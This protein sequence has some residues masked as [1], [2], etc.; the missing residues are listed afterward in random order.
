MNE[1]MQEIQSNPD[2]QLIMTFLQSIR[3]GDMDEEA[4]QQLRAIGDR[5]K[6]GGVLSDRER[7]M[8]TSVVGAMP[9]VPVGAPP[10]PTGDQGPYVPPQQPMPSA[11]GTTYGPSSGVTVDP[12][13][14]PM[15]SMRPQARP[16]R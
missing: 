6:N 15:T 7:E 13:S 4:S 12:S 16:M 14:A 2:Y 10:M 11:G 3:P 1:D 8:F 9:Q 5:I